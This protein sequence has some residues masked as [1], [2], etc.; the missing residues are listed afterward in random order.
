MPHSTSR[1]VFEEKLTPILYSFLLS[2]AKGCAYCFAS[3]WFKASV[4]DLSTLNSKT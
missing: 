1:L 4:A 2:K 3:I